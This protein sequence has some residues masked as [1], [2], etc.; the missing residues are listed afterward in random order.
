MNIHNIKNTRKIKHQGFVLPTVLVLSIVLLTL[1]LSVFQLTSTIA[2]SL[3]DQYWQKVSKQAAQAG[4]S[5]MSAC[6]DQGLSGS[7][8]PASIT[9]NDTC[10]G[11]PLSTPQPSIFTNTTDTNPVPNPYRSSFTIYK[12]TAGADGIQK[13][14]IVGTVSILNTA[15]TTTIRSYTTEMT[16]IINGPMQSVNQIT[17]GRYNTCASADGR[18]HCW[19]LNDYGQLGIGN[20]NN[21]SVPIAVSTSGALSGKTVTQVSGNYWHNCALADGKAYCWGLNTSGQLG[22]DTTIN[23]SSPVEVTSTGGT[24]ALNGKVVTQVS[25]GRTH[26]C[27]LASGKVYCW[28]SN[29]H[30]QLGNGNNINSSSP[31]QVSLTGGTGEL[32]GRFVTQVAVG[33]EHSCAL[34]DGKVFC[35][36]YNADGQ[37]G[38]NSLVYTNVP[39]AVVASG[40]GAAL[41]GRYV[42]EIAGGYYHTCALADGQAFC[43]GF[44]GSGQLGNNS[45]ATSSVPVAVNTTSGAL[46]GKKI[47]SLAPGR[48]HSCVLADQAICW[49]LNDDGQLGN[50]NNTSS[51][52]PVNVSTSGVLNGKTVTQ[53]TGGYYHTCAIASGQAYCWGNNADG[54]LG[55]N[56]TTSSNVPVKAF[57]FASN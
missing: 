22:N 5:Y 20:N 16:A 3:T 4:A 57:D 29:T 55:N 14:R 12:P 42:T 28:G 41:N 30:G 37:L 11:V 7:T 26:T 27:A 54:Q 23:S 35:W 25:A 2:R 8:W 13:A 31:V 45:T 39:V 15:G 52:L 40:G 44:N 36:G 53:V 10:L 1:G 46:V 9:Q 21:S 18:A 33:A 50:G 49:G 51:L 19:G 56:T 32:N 6:V 17:R 34:A 47:V 38:N 24:G 48:N 43:W